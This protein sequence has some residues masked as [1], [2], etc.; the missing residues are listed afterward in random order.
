M[1]VNHHIDPFSLTLQVYYG[2]VQQ[3][4]MVRGARGAMTAIHAPMLLEDAVSDEALYFTAC[5]YKD[6]G[7]GKVHAR[8]RV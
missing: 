1:L 8:A 2:R 7:E 6:D 5:W 3:M 4:F